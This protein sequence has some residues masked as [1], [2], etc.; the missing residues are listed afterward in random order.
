[1][2]KLLVALL[3]CCSALGAYAQ[4]E[5]TTIKVGS[6][7]PELKFENPSGQQME[8]SKITKDRVVLLDFWASWCRPCRTANPRLVELYDRYKEKNF[9]AAK[10]GFTIVSVSL[11]Q[12]KDAW[13]KAI[14]DDK[15]AW[16][17]HMSDLGG[18]QSKPAQIYGVEYVPQAFL[19]GPDGKVLAT[20]QFAEQ[21]EVDLQK[22]L[23]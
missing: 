11:D 19:L 21:A 23:K 4:F 20:Y 2:K 9:K 18:W 22:M 12:N 17:F 14:Q 6:K 3:L 7:A 1:M 15:L 8:L 10:K 16:E 13:V 5:N